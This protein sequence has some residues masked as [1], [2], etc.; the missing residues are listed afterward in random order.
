[1]AN[2]ARTSHSSNHSLQL[3]SFVPH[4]SFIQHCIFQCKKLL[5][6]KSVYHCQFIPFHF[7]AF[8][9]P[10]LLIFLELMCQGK[11]CTPFDTNAVTMWASLSCLLAYCLTY[12]AGEMTRVRSFWSQC[13]VSALRCSNVL[14]G[15]LLSASLASI[16][17]PDIIKPFFYVLCIMFSMGELLYAPFET[18][19]KWIQVRLLGVSDTQE[20][21]ERQGS[22]DEHWLVSTSTDR[23]NRLPV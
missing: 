23:T 21:Q 17:F 11:D 5:P 7:L 3:H 22:A 10:A 20:K 15:L 18:L 4:R 19:W 2:I 8:I 6:A 9:V 16:C 14:F 12:W 13:Y 1:M